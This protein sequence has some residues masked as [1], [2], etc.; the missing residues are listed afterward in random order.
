MDFLAE[1]LIRG[2][3]YAIG[4]LGLGKGGKAE[5]SDRVQS[6]EPV[7]TF[8]AD[9]TGIIEYDINCCHLSP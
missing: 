9:R 1:F 7:D 2:Q 8:P 6:P 3:V 5:D 4:Y